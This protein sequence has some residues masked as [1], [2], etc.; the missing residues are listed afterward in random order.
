MDDNWKIYKR[1][2]DVNAL[3]VYDQFI[4]YTIMARSYA[5]HFRY[6]EAV[7][8]YDLAEEQSSSKEID[9][10]S[11]AYYKLNFVITRGYIGKYDEGKFEKQVK[12]HLGVL[13]KKA[14]FEDDL[15]KFTLALA[16]VAFNNRVRG[17]SY[18][19]KNLILLLDIYP[20]KVTGSFLFIR[21]HSFS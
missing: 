4:Y 15:I 7:R 12:P 18:H 2:I 17:L 14:T 11:L 8:Y 3:N 10:Y 20:Q 6:N 19:I 1:S 13:S 21:F 9:R 16:D 5:L